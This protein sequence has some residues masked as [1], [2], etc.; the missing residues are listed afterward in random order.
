MALAGFLAACGGVRFGE[1]R[2]RRGQAG[3]HHRST[4]ASI[5]RP[6]QALI[7]AF[8]RQTGI[9]VKERDGDEDAL[10]EE[11]QQEGSA[12][13]ADVFF[14][15]NSPALMSLQEKGLLAP[16]PAS[17]LSQVPAQYSSPAGDW[18]GVSARVSVLVYNTSQAPAVSQLPT[19]V[20]GPG[21][22]R[23]EGQAGP[24]AD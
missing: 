15:E 17:V 24:G 19:S 21:Q 12:S 20:H 11:I 7:A 13:P 9:H 1:R 2:G 5:S 8:E 23:V 22:P 10:A 16:V 6:P 4:T 18:V 3:H 14:T